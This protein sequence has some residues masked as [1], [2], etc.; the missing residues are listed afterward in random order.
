MM[1]L[2]L[3]YFLEKLRDGLGRFARTNSDVIAN[4]YSMK[5]S[6]IRLRDGTRDETS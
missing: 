4:I 2:G 6:V 3:V 5:I 1:F